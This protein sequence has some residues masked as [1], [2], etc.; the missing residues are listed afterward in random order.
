MASVSSSPDKNLS[1]PR[2]LVEWWVQRVPKHGWIATGKE[3]FSEL[4]DFILES[5]PERRRQRYGDVEFDWDHRVDTTSATVGFRD[6]LLGVFHSAYQPTEPGPFREM[7]GQLPLDYREFTFIDLGCGK[8]R[9]LLMASDY[10]FRRVVGVELLPSLHQIAVE[11]ANKYAKRRQ[12]SAPIEVVCA[13]ARNFNFPG[14]PLV[15]YLFHPFPEP[16]LEEVLGNLDRSLQQH[17][18]PAYVI[19]Y[20][21]VLE[22]VLSGR[23]NWRRAARTEHCAIYVTA[24]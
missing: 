2:L 20:N 16:V 7:I 9:T 18:R 10:P 24:A 4:R 17:P 6:R 5:T 12:L 21:P 11:N 19:Y 14:G 1:L 3:F 8:G 23:V 13:D 22:H 15:V